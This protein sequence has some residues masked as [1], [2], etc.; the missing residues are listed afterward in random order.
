MATN[1]IT[2]KIDGLGKMQKDIANAVTGANGVYTKAMFQATA[3]V[4][5]KA[6]KNLYKGHGLQTGTLRRSIFTKVSALKG[7]IGVGE[8][9]GPYVEY[10]TRPHTIRPK[11]KQALFFQSPNGTIGGQSKGGKL[12][13][14]G[15]YKVVHHPGT[16]EMPYMRPAAESSIGQINE[17]FKEAIQVVVRKAAGK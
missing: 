11:V 14:F 13:T 1:N 2:I 8:K 17:I 5:S 3:A 10:G 4:Q 15:I 12:K 7:I 16:P 9:Y 6:R